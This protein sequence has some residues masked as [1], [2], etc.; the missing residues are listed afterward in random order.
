MGFLRMFGFVGITGADRGMPAGEGRPRAPGTPPGSLRFPGT[1]PGRPMTGDDCWPG[2]AVTEL[3]GALGVTGL[4][5]LWACK[6]R[7]LAMMSFAWEPPIMEAAAGGG[8]RALLR[9][10]SGV[11]EGVMFFG[12]ETVRSEGNLFGNRSGGA[13]PGAS[14]GVLAS[15]ELA[16]PGDAGLSWKSRTS[17]SSSGVA[18]TESGVSAMMSVAFSHAP[19][20]RWRTRS[21]AEGGGGRAAVPSRY[22]YR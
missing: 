16:E 12:S 9:M 1:P 2:E 7:A 21:T 19:A 14:R 11:D 18:G 20:T 8:R 22:G 4:F 10:P 6:A 13:S 15:E 5:I 3:G 17:M